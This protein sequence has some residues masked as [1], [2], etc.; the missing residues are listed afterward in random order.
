M[1]Y[2]EFFMQPN[3]R[4]TYEEGSKEIDELI[5]LNNGYVNLYKSVYKFNNNVHINN[6]IINRIFI[7]FDPV[8]KDDEV[9]FENC[10]T[11]IG[12]LVSNYIDFDVLYS[13]RGFHLFICVD[14]I[15]RNLKNPKVAIKNFVNE[16]HQKTN[17]T[18]DPAVVGDIRRVSRVVNTINMKT[19]RY[20]IRLN[21]YQINNFTLEQIKS[22]AKSPKNIKAPDMLRGVDIRKFDNDIVNVHHSTH[23][24]S[25][26]NV[27]ISISQ[28]FPLCIRNFLA[29]PDLGYVNRGRLI[30]FLRDMG[31]GEDEVINILEQS[32][33]TEKFIHCV[34]EEHQVSYL[35]ART[36]IVFPNCSTMQL[37][38]CCWGCGGNNL[39]L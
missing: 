34:E 29:M 17:T 22:L 28:N 39:Y 13:G 10:K 27:N 33:S 21:S 7:D 5:N 8:H 32:L 23:N 26:N 9:A 14:E 35:F 30:I 3:F 31:Y 12:Y 38:D 20:C 19:R 25:F 11:I 16:L 37:D 2:E 6:A 15:S 18:S 4:K 36:N 24:Q 1:I